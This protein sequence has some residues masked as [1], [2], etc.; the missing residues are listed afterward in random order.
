MN[1][2]IFKTVGE[3]GVTCIS[4]YATR[5]EARNAM[6]AYDIGGVK[7]SL[8]KLSEKGLYNFWLVKYTN[9]C[10]FYHTRDAA[11]KS[12]FG[13]GKVSKVFVEAVR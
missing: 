10:E 9:F 6:R 1:K 11:R 8:W 12:H 2:W 5:E 7:K 3:D 13:C 4:N